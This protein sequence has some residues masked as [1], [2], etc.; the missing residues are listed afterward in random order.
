[1]PPNVL[2]EQSK[3]FQWLAGIAYSPTTIL[4]NILIQNCWDTIRLICCSVEFLALYQY[5]QKS[6]KVFMIV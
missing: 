3:S 5:L 4:N 6:R 1:M 2:R